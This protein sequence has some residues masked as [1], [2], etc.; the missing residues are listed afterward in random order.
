MS[1]SKPDPIAIESIHGVWYLRENQRR[2]D[3][4]WLLKRVSCLPMGWGQRFEFHVNGEFVDAY[5]TRCGND[6][7]V[8]HWSGIW[9][10]NEER[11]LLFVQING[12]Q[13]ES[14]AEP[15]IK[16]S[17][18]DLRGREFHLIE[19]SDEKLVLMPITKE[20]RE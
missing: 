15:H 1:T 10:W 17:E 8:H 18:D 3:G 5:S 20:T 19:A 12:V 14:Y 16:P 7:S 6:S 11:G 9:N 13:E 4:S 2:P